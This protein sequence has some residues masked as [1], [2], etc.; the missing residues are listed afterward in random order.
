MSKKILRVITSMDPAGGGPCQGIR[1][2]IPALKALGVDNE[3]VCLDSHDAEYLGAD[4]FTIHAL[5]A[6]KGPWAYNKNL[7]PWLVKNASNYDAIIIH[8][9][10][11]FNSFAVFKALKHLAP[12]TQNPIPYYVMPHG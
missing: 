2:S 4:D 12:K 8:G 7:I 6:A 1:N 10:W 9:L 3:V 5:G 11:Q